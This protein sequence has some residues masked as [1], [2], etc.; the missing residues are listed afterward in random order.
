MGTRREGQKRGK[1]NCQFVGGLASWF[2]LVPNPHD[3]TFGEPFFDVALRIERAVQGRFLIAGFC[4]RAAGKN[5]FCLIRLTADGQLDA[6]FGQA[7]I[8]SYASQAGGGT[9]LDN[10]SHGLVVQPD[11]KIVLAGYARA[12][13][14]DGGQIEVA[15]YSATRCSET[16]STEVRISPRRTGNCRARRLVAT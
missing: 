10:T 14:V 12:A 9:D 13:G 16:A 8:Q 2:I 7:D 15:A 5:D 11:R 3:S 1:A 4:N 6:D